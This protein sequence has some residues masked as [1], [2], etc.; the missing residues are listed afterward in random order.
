MRPKRMTRAECRSLTCRD[1]LYAAAPCIAEKGR[2][3]SSVEDIAAR[4]GYTR[5]AFY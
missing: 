2:A 3:A 4:A 5:G 1:L